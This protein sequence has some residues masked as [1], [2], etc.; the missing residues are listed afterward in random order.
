MKKESK[1]RLM[2]KGWSKEDIEKADEIINERKLQDKSRSTVHANRILFWT[3]LLV[4]VIGNTLVSF[5]LIPLL[6]VFNRLAMNA[7]VVVIGFSIGL[8]FNFLVWDIEEHIT[9]KHHLLAATIIP[10]LAI[11]NLYAMVKISNAIN[12]VFTLTEVRGDPLTV[13][14]LYVIAFLTPYLFTLF[15]KKKIKTY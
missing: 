13:S 4:M 1:T 15:Y 6:L 3:V 11:F 9:R 14:A 5:I 7:F 10:I 12:N 8:L 2:K